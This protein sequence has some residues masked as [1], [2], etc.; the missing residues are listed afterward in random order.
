MHRLIRDQAGHE[1]VA[2]A[3]RFVDHRD[4]GLGRL[5]TERRAAAKRAAVGI[6]D[7]GD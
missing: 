4:Y 2:D 6:E 5:T 1:V 3:M 7:P